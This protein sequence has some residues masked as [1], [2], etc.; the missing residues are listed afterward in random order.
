MYTFQRA[1]PEDAQREDG[2][3]VTRFVKRVK[4]Q[5]REDTGAE[6]GDEVQ[7]EWPIALILAKKA[8]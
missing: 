2:D 1:H 5:V 8:A 7:V 3:I 6:P 4:D